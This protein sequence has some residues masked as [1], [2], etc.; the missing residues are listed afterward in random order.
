MTFHTNIKARISSLL[1]SSA[2]GKEAEHL[3][4]SLVLLAKWRGV[5][6]KNTLVAKA[7]LSVQNG[8]FAGMDFLSDSAEGCH[9]PK[10]LGSYE[11][12]LHPFIEAAISK[13]YETLLN[14]GSAEGYYAVGLARRMPDVRV[15]AWDKAPHARAICRSLAEKNDVSDR[16]TIFGEASGGEIA[17]HVSGKTLLICDIEGYELT[18]LDP[19]N[20]PAFKNMDLIVEA[21]DCY[22]PGLS[23]DLTQRFSP[24][25]DLTLVADDGSRTLGVTTDWFL[26]LS[27]LD[28]LLAVWEWRIG[29]TPW[30][31]MTVKS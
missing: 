10:L 12:P 5:L 2:D 31:V 21:H 20:Q 16:I 24:T 19:I 28:Q 30:L 14:V 8:P 9:I 26:S 27:H 1:G 29:P 25:H 23:K 18:L 11:Q 17:S 7:G 22:R 13:R 6:I 3:H 4:Q 15:F